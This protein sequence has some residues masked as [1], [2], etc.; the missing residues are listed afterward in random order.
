MDVWSLAGPSDRVSGE[1]LS[2][3]M[4]RGTGLWKRLTASLL[5]YSEV[6]NIKKEG[7]LR[8]QRV[9]ARLR[10]QGDSCLTRLE[11]VNTVILGSL[12][13]SRMQEKIRGSIRE[14]CCGS[15][16]REIL[17]D[18]IASPQAW[19]GHAEMTRQHSTITTQQYTHLHTLHIPD[20]S[21]SGAITILQ[22]KLLL[23]WDSNI[24]KIQFNNTR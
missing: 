2:E 11:V 6:E 16:G 3:V 12:L 20:C 23:H 4:A 7:L 14:P 24:T 19:S 15:M 18:Q 10:S 22:P 13:G 21:W 9:Q 17:T 8:K 5:N 1:P